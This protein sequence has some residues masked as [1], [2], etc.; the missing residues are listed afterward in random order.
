MQ[1]GLMDKHLTDA[2]AQA[3]VAARKRAG[4]SQEQLA[5]H[6]DLDRTYISGIERG[7]RNITLGSLER[8]VS[9][10]GMKLPD[11]L[12]EVINELELP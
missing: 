8:I 10:L 6:S 9:G 4:L 1:S 2:V 12:A 11:F 5:A 3:L 7:L